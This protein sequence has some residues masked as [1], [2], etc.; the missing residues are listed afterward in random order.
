M[1]IILQLQNINL[2]SGKAFLGLIA[3]LLLLIHMLVMLFLVV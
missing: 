3:S 1:A 2:G